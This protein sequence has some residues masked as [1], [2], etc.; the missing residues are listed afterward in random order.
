MMINLNFFPIIIDFLTTEK[1]L[2]ILNFI[3]LMT[4]VIDRL[5]ILNFKKRRKQID[6]ENC[7]NI[8]L[9]YLTRDDIVQLE[10]LLKYPPLKIISRKI[11]TK[12]ENYLFSIRGQKDYIFSSR[13]LQVLKENFEKDLINLRGLISKYRKLSMEKEVRLA[14]QRQFL[15]IYDNDEYSFLDYNVSIEEDEVIRAVEKV[16]ESYMNFYTEAKKLHHFED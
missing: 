10:Y 1:G 4:L 9:N 8:F 15:Y 16:K 14:L 5:G 11:L 3:L 6:T 12:V 7:K 13:K 2:N